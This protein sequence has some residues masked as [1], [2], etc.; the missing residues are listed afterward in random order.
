MGQAMQKLRFVQE[1][2]ILMQVGEPEQGNGRYYHHA[3]RLHQC[4]RTGAYFMVLEYSATQWDNGKPCPNQVTELFSLESRA[5]F[6]A[7]RAESLQCNAA[8]PEDGQRLNRELLARIDAL[9]GDPWRESS[10]DTTNE[11]R[12]L[13]WD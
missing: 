13:V 5:P 6:D 11:T 4:D 12:E 10:P 8:T 2:R 7:I 1:A 9:A 3:L